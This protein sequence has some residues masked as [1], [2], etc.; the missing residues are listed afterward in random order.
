MLDVRCVQN[1]EEFFQLGEVWDNVLRHSA[2]DNVFL[3]HEWL[4]SWWE[5]FG[6]NGRLHILLFYDTS[7][8]DHELIGIFPGYIQ[9]AGLFL[10]INKLCFL[11]S[12]VVTSDF[13]DMIVM[14]GKEDDV[15][16][17]FKEY[18]KQP[19]PFHIMEITDINVNSAFADV[20]LNELPS[21]WTTKTWPVN[22]VCP[23]I[24]LPDSSETY[25]SELGAKVSKNFRYY[26]KKL[27]A[28]GMQ[29]E[30][31]SDQEKLPQATDDFIALHNHRRT[32]KGDAGV[33]ASDAQRTFYRA[34]FERFLD[35]G[36][37]DLVFL[38]IGAER[39]AAV[40]QFDYGDKIYY[41]QTGYDIAWDKSSV[42]FVLNGLMIER[43]I[44]HG[45]TSFEFLRGDETYKY[46]FGVTGATLLKDISIHKGSVRANLHVQYRHRRS[47]VR[48]FVKKLIKGKPADLP[49]TKH[50]KNLEG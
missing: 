50:S 4:T 31:I 24:T 27:E 28:Q 12:E 16:D 14:H 32:Q 37:L 39:I 11:G 44:M 1:Q 13:L 15:Y 35:K 25:F 26:R 45:K 47:G 42:G 30:S 17:A 29:L 22:K 49:N 20:L 38:K 19:W 48:G 6:D 40:C 8:H 41:Y 33:F 9:K 5:S 3:T 2:Q 36:W 34:V 18:L 10:P 46:R 7:L 43:A 23:C 21:S